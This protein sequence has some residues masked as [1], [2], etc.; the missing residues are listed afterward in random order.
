MFD[1]KNYDEWMFFVDELG[2]QREWLAIGHSKKTTMIF[3]HKC[4]SILSVRNVNN[5]DLSLI[6]VGRFIEFQ[7][8]LNQQVNGNNMIG[9]TQGFSPKK[10]Q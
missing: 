10:K 9:S 8:R 7:V 4:A 5:A 1:N 6:D 2:L 3:S